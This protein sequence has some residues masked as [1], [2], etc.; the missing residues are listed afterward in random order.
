MVVKAN[1]LIE[2]AWKSGDLRYKLHAGQRKIWETLL[3]ASSKLFVVNCARQFGKSYLAVVYC[4]SKAVSTPKFKI[5]Y[6]SAFRDDLK[7]YIIPHF[8]AV[9]EDCP[10]SMRPK[11]VAS[12]NKYLFPNGS[13]IK[14]IGLDKN[15]D[16]LRGNTI[17]LIMLDE[18]AFVSKL[19]Y[20]YRSVI[21]PATMHRPKAK[22]LMISTPPESPDHDYTEFALRAR[23]EG[24]YAL[25]DIY[26]NPMLSKEIIADLIIEAGGEE[27]TDWKR[28]Y[29][30]E[31][32][33]DENLAIVPEW[34]PDYEMNTPRPEHFQ[35][36]HKYVSMDL[37]IRDL[38]VV[39]FAYYDF[40]RCKLVVKREHVVNGPKMTTDQLA[41]DV[42]KIEK[43]VFL[44]YEPYLRV[45]DNNNLL[46]LNDLN[47][48]HK[49]HFLPTSKDSLEAMV[50]NARLWVKDGKVEIDPSCQQL[51]G[52]LRYGIWME[53]RRDFAR[54][55]V[56]GHFDALAAL[57]Y[58]VRNVNVITNPI[59]P[60]LGKSRFEHFMPFGNG[61]HM[62]LGEIEL[63]KSWG[64]SP[65]AQ[66]ARC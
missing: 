52:C 21:I 54:S 45:S 26:Q 24:N 46:L 22:V 33:V 41:D 57:I 14:V 19:K 2:A 43:E 13:E 38:T 29:L 61:A 11:W 36:Y 9:L 62:E 39:L 44:G 53:S 12:Q 59:P 64:I 10:E 1:K 51:I 60:N 25:F 31:F 40:I 56:Y 16:G 7:E 3:G 37:G 49:I 20:L 65:K 55:P 5:K 58:L 48:K 4:C 35:F 42:R 63:A 47:I 34:R 50:N 28:E 17:D 8:E 15:P 27:S 6:C 18:A 30:C 23:A 32:V 66:I